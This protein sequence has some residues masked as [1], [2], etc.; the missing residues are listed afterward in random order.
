MADTQVIRSKP[1]PLCPDCGVKMTLR[2]PVRGQSW[3][4]FWGCSRYPIC[5]GT[6][7]IRPDGLPEGDDDWVEGLKLGDW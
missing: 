2:R 4:P 1:E 7:N 5:L 6:R 3:K